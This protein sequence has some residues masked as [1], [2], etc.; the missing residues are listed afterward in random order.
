MPRLPQ[1]LRAHPRRALA[2]GI[3][4]LAGAIA[5]IAYLATAHPSDYPDQL[6]GA[7][8]DVSV[9]QALRDHHITL[10]ATTHNLRYSANQHVEGD[11]YPLAAVFSFPCAQTP[12]FATANN[13]NQVSHSYL[14]LNIAVYDLATN[15]GWNPTSQ[16][17]T[18]YEHV[19][20]TRATLSVLIQPAVTSICTGYLFSNKY[21]D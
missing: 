13:L 21:N 2:T 6:P 15:L 18:W 20:G 4:L 17:A 16:G 19:E 12:A 3:A 1:R 10:P 8:S 9:Q 5:V 11:D 14:L 7:H